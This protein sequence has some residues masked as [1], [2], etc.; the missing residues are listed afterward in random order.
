[1]TIGHGPRV[2]VGYLSSFIISRKFTLELMPAKHYRIKSQRHDRARGSR[3][4]GR[5]ELVK[6]TSSNTDYTEDKQDRKNTNKKNT[7][8]PSKKPR[9]FCSSKTFLLESHYTEQSWEK[10]S[11][12][13]GILNLICFMSVIKPI[14]ISF[15]DFLLSCLIITICDSIP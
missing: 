6:E 10:K 8:T 7:P 11:F 4:E 5:V 3:G 13:P 14:I 9:P 2:V 15:V 1:M 12:L